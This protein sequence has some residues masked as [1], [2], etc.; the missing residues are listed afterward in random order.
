MIMCHVHEFK[1]PMTFWKRLIGAIFSPYWYNMHVC[2]VLP[3]LQLIKSSKSLCG[4]WITNTP[5]ENA[6]NSWTKKCFISASV[7]ASWT[8]K[9]EN[10]RECGPTPVNDSP[11]PKAPLR[12]NGQRGAL[13]FQNKVTLC[14]WGRP[15]NRKM[16][17]M[18]QLCSTGV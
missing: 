7:T 6:L 18:T 4:H 15:L 16:W 17:F 11:N 8:V 2:L 1:I 5:A 3:Y 12:V 10:W 13:A 9:P 14:F